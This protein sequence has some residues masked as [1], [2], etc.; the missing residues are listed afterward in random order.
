MLASHTP[1]VKTTGITINSIIS[2]IVFKC[3]NS[4]ESYNAIGETGAELL[5]GK[6]TM[7]LRTKDSNKPIM[8]RGAFITDEEVK[9]MLNK[10]P[11]A[12]GNLKMLEIANPEIASTCINENAPKE[13]K[14]LAGIIVWTLKRAT[15]SVHQLQ[16]EFHK[17][18]E[19]C[20]EFMDILE[21]LGI[22]SAPFAKQARKVIPTC[23][24]EL[25]TE[26]KN[27]LDHYGYT[28]ENIRNFFEGRG[29]EKAI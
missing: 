27:L 20:K 22:V 26:T 24:E 9:N 15:V 25:S 10:L 3:V 16:K 8:L 2:R 12:P 14:E 19:K 5:T 11:T 29:D 21:Q 4:R 18:N 7:L 28:T 1:T 6:G 13:R 17:N 23:I